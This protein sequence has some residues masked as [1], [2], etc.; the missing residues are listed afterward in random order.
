MRKVTILTVLLVLG[1]SREATPLPAT[2]SAASDPALQHHEIRFE[3]LPAPF[4]TPSAG[5]PPSVGSP[6]PNAQLHLPPGFRIAV[7]A[8]GLDDPRTMLLAPNGDVLVAE[9]GAGKITLLRDENRD[10]IAEKKFN[11]AGGLREPFGLA[12]NG[13]WLYVGDIDAVVRLPYSAGQT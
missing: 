5:N 12:F 7:Y 6:P 1:C 10:G 8:S 4:A 9:P 11:F 3:Q 2:V 13:P